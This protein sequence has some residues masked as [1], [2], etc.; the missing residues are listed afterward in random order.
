MQLKNKHIVVTGANGGIGKSFALMCAREEAIV[1]LVVRTRDENLINEVKRAGAL[2]VFL[3]EA[4]L[5]IFESIEELIKT[6]HQYPIS[7][8]FNN[9]GL[10]TGG[11]IEEQPIADIYKMLQVNVN[12]LIHLSRAIIPGMIERKSGKIINNSSVSAIMHFP[13]AST[14]A[15]SKAAVAAFTDCIRLEL[16]DKNVST[17]LLITPGIKTKMFD[18]IATL[19]SKNIKVP[20]GSITSDEYAVR[21]KN[22]ILADDD[23]LLPPLF[24]STG[25][26]LSF[27]ANFKRGF[28]K[29]ISSQFK[30]K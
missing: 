30:R 9:A 11:L 16:K 5:S 24:S 4:D 6:L 10:L 22:A 2:E 7:I 19:Y 29:I 26:A 14:Y 18:N 3:W 8:L 20:E 27:S 23:I 28:E 21:I 17:L 12:A 15:A 1:H 25:I 13:C